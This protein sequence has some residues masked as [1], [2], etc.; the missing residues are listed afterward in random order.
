MNRIEGIDTCEILRDDVLQK[1]MFVDKSQPAAI[2][3]P[4]NR[5]VV[6]LFCEKNIQQLNGKRKPRR[7]LYWK[8]LGV[9]IA[10]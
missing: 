10:V 3:A 6:L 4:Y 2:V 7:L 9:H 5:I 1:L 8:N